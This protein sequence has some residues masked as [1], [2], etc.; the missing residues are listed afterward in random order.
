MLMLCFLHYQITSRVLKPIV[1]LTNEITNPIEFKKKAAEKKE[2]LYKL[3]HPSERNDSGDMEMKDFFDE[4]QQP[5]R[6]ES[7]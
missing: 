4:N 5:E 3:N 7:F 2:A 1:E 6:M